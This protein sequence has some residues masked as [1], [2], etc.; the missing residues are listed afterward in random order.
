MSKVTL[1]WCGEAMNQESREPIIITL[2]H[3]TWHPKGILETERFRL[4]ERRKRVRGYEGIPGH[5]EPPKLRGSTSAKC[6]SVRK[7]H[8]NLPDTPVD[9]TG[10][11]K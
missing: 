5:D 7:P 3:L 9:L 6:K 8:A 11:P 1:S 2:P 4:K 10:A